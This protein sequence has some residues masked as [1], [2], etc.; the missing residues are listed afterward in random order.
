MGSSGN[1]IRITIPK[2]A[3]V[4][5]ID[6]GT[7]G[8]EDRI[9]I[10]RIKGRRGNAINVMT[11][12]AISSQMSRMPMIPRET[13][14]GEERMSARNVETRTSGEPFDVAKVGKIGSS[15]LRDVTLNGESNLRSTKNDHVVD[16]S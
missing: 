15:L 5:T 9:L 7:I 1:E 8:S 13:V 6:D 14:T 12:E 2:D 3:T 10:G 16:T 11:E 4:A